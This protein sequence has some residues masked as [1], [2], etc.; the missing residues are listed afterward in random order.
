LI[1][2]CSKLVAVAICGEM[3]SR[4]TMSWRMS[5]RRWSISMNNDPRIPLPRRNW[6]TS[7]LTK[8]NLEHA[9]GSHWSISVCSKR[10]S[11]LTRE[12]LEQAQRQKEKQLTMPSSPEGSLTFLSIYKRFVPSYKPL[13]SKISG[14][15]DSCN[16]TMISWRFRKMLTVGL[17]S[18]WEGLTYR[19]RIRIMGAHRLKYE[20]RV[21]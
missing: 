11:E 18:L 10:D 16:F 9:T 7:G 3:E 6:F 1:R 4:R 13:G 8:A 21:W 12:E 2:S 14:A 5:L 17:N 19:S 20:R 15:T